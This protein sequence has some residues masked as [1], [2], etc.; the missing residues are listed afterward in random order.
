MNVDCRAMDKHLRN[1][2]IGGVG[3]ILAIAGFSL[4]VI[5][6]LLS[7]VY[8]NF[9]EPLPPTRR[10]TSVATRSRVHSPTRRQRTQAVPA[11]ILTNLRPPPTYNIVVNVSD[12]TTPTPRNKTTFV[13]SHRRNTSEEPSASDSSNASRENDPSSTNP[14]D[15][16]DPKSACSNSWSWNRKKMKARSASTLVER[17]SDAMNVTEDGMLTPTSTKSARKARAPKRSM[18]AVPDSPA[19]PDIIQSMETAKSFFVE[20]KPKDKKPRIALSPTSASMPRAR[21]QPYA[22]PYFAP[23]P[24]SASS[25]VLPRPKAVRSQTLPPPVQRPT[26]AT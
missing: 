5:T 1:A 22:A 25:L 19:T 20:R 9:K 24:T 10:S 15:S 11:P 26:T 12:G 18:T 3:F 23:R 8:P 4:S 13:V 2:V 21:T 7:Y 17:E 14:V 6:A 16:A